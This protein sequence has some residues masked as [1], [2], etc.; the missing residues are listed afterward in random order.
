MNKDSLK[1]L[2]ILVKSCEAQVFFKKSLLIKQCSLN[3]NYFHLNKIYYSFQLSI[4][5]STHTKAPAQLLRYL[6]TCRR[7]LSIIGGAY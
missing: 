2:I 4:I 1:L 7:R 6:A 5:S 3:L